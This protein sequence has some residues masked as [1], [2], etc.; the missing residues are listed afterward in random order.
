[1]APEASLADYAD[2]HALLPALLYTST[3]DTPLMTLIL[4]LLSTS[5]TLTSLAFA[6]DAPPKADAAPVPTVPELTAPVVTVPET[7]A[8]P[9]KPTL[10][11]DLR[12]TYLAGQPIL[13]R[14]TVE[15]TGK[16][17]LSFPDLSLR[18]W[19]VYF[20]ILDSKGKKA[21]YHNTA[22]ASDSGKSWTLPSR[23]RKQVLL[24]IPQSATLKAGSYTLNLRVED[25]AGTVKLSSHSFSIE[26]I[27][28]SA[29]SVHYE[30]LGLERTG[31]QVAW[32]QKGAQGFDVYLE[33]SDATEPRK[34]LAQYFVMHSETAADPTLSLALPSARWDRYVY[35]QRDDRSVQ[36]ARLQGAGQPAASRLIQTPYPKLELLGRGATDKEGGLHL[37]IWIP[38]PVGSGGELMVLS[39]RDR[40]QRSYRSLAKYDS[41]PAW[42]ES[43]IDSG[44]NLRLVFP[45][46]GN[47]DQY[48]IVSSTELP[49]AGK[50][51][52]K[53]EDG[54]QALAARYAV[55]AASEGRPGG[56]ALFVLLEEPEGKASGQWFALDGTPLATVAA[57]TIGEGR[58]SDVLPLGYDDYAVLVTRPDGQ[59]SVLQPAQAELKAKPQANATL[60]GD[61]SRL[62]LRSVVSSGGPTQST[63]LR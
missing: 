43:G 40:G 22:P 48:T 27:R 25:P 61:D 24:D 35:W 4:A 54:K 41:Q 38:A 42:I 30:P 32:T 47:L 11:A 57:L 50:R 1:V 18:P 15:N 10:S 2:H 9:A 63:K 37:P 56:L 58:I 8:A 52:I 12:P 14:L 3:E 7:A 5:C 13:V 53:A 33:Q 31:H 62:W 44:G 45:N 34:V 36:V 55:L 17:A 26:P 46:Q 16:E 6:Q 39:L 28:P 19:L 60:V 21:T 59:L 51:L 49:G 29:G 20:E 23:S